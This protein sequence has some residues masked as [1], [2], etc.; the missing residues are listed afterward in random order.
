MI[1]DNMIQDKTIQD[2][3]SDLDPPSDDGDRITDFFSRHGGPGTMARRFGR[4]QGGL[5]GWSEIVARD[6]HVLRC[7]WSR[8]GTLEE[9]KYSEVAPRRPA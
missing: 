1:H 6:G 8:S 4:S 5:Q 7:D 9:I 2:Q 3:E